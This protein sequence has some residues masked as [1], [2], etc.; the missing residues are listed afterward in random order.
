MKLF[1]NVAFVSGC[2][3]TLAVAQNNGLPASKAAIKVS[4][5]TITP[6]NG[7]WTTFLTTQI[8]T[9]PKTLEIGVSL[10][11]GLYTSTSVNGGSPTSSV[12]VR[13][14]VDGTPALPG[15]VVFDRRSQAL[16]GT[17]ANILTN[18]STT[19]SVSGS[20]ANI[21]APVTCTVTEPSLQF[22]LD[23]LEANTFYFVQNIGVGIHTIQVQVSGNNTGGGVAV[24][25]PGVVTVEEVRLIHDAEI[26]Q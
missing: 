6:A 9:A 23:T 3:A 13:V 25:G 11:T 5:L 26:I 2:L 15:A 8:K 1:L 12:S 14:L 21:T 16:S 18:C 10:D 24:V 22:V 20:P 17:L 4:N 19:F 7:S